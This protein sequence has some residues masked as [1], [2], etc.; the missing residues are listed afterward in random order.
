MLQKSEPGRSLAD[1][2]K[3]IVFFYCKNQVHKKAEFHKLK[4]GLKNNNDD[5]KT[6]ITMQ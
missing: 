4:E 3:K 6:E 2:R 5:A 1:S